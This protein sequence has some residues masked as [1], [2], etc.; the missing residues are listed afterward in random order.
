MISILPGVLLVAGAPIVDW[1]PLTCQSALHYFIR[2]RVG[3]RGSAVTVQGLTPDSLSPPCL[4]RKA[5][6]PPSSPL[7]N[8]LSSSD[9]IKDIFLRVSLSKTVDGTRRTAP[10]RVVFSVGVPDQILRGGVKTQQAAAANLNI[11]SR[12]IVCT[13]MQDFPNSCFSFSAVFCLAA[14]SPFSNKSSFPS[15]NK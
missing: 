10:C 7:S 15:C 9:F 11:Q 4:V 1:L 2:A 13:L 8:Q 6:F 14:C 12:L 3:A 5:A